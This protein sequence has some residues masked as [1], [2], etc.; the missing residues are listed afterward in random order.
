[1]KK[2]D[3]GNRL[4]HI[5]MPILLG[6]AVGIIFKDY[7]SYIETL[8][9]T[10]KIPSIVFPIVWSILYILIGIW[11]DFFERD[12]NNINKIVYY[13]LLFMNFLFT[14]VLFYFK[15]IVLALIIV[16]VLLVGNAYL[17]L[18]S[19]RYGKYSYLLIPYV[20]WLMFALTLMFD[21]LINNVL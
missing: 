15:Q 8:E 7:T 1:M 17:L 5:L 2:I 4:F 9:R 12:T 3:I 13:I 16:G 14:P 10:I 18:R 11:Y 20:L 21:L 19:Y 6:T